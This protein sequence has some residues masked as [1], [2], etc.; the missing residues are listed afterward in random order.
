MK[1]IEFIEK[2]ALSAGGLL[3]SES[4]ISKNCEPEN[5][6]NVFSLK[7]AKKAFAIAMWDF[8]WLLRHHRLGE[9]ENF[10]KV[11]DD[12][13]ERG[14]NAVR[15]DCFP[16]FIAADSNGKIEEV[17]YHPKSDWQVALWGNQYSIYS[18]PRKSLLEFLTLC[19]KKHIYVGLSTWFMRHGTE[20]NLEFK[21]LESI[22]RAWDETLKFI[23]DNNL[24]DIVIYV[25]LLNEYPQWHGFKWLTDKIA[26]LSNKENFLA[27]NPDINDNIPD[28][29]FIKSKEEIYNTAK[30]NFYKQFISDLII[31]LKK[32]GEAY[33]F[34]QV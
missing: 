16:Q 28:E 10:D 30:I 21:G 26:S 9:F 5:T 13:A 33:A 23:K 20:R 1:R 22:S 27:K 17:Y 31:N 8:S 25:D 7:N 2:S 15:I 19:K 6:K 24:L 18:N 14:Y 12:L 32:N 3:I 11:L 29:N 4:L 34:L